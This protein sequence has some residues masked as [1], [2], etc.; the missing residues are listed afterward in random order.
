MQ[1]FAASGAGATPLRLMK[2]AALRCCVCLPVRVARRSPFST[3]SVL[4]TNTLSPEFL[5]AFRDDVLAAEQTASQER[6]VGGLYASCI[7]KGELDHME[8][9]EADARVLG[10]IE[11]QA[12]SL[13]ARLPDLPDQAAAMRAALKPTREEVEADEKFESLK[14][15]MRDRYQAQQRRRRNEA[16]RIDSAME[17]VEDGTYTAKYAAQRSTGGI[18]EIVDVTPEQAEQI[19]LLKEL[20]DTKRQMRELQAKFDAMTA[21]AKASNKT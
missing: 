7:R 8:S 1:R 21:S 13:F 2:A 4:G 17:A 19:N 16:A 15:A 3:D 9:P 5:E 10:K 11:R 14:E 20:E 6:A 18:D 12:E